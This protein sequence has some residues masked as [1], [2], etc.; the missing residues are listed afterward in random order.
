ME[1]LIGRKFNRLTVIEFDHK[2]KYYNSFWK[3]R[4]DC[5]NEVIVRA[6]GLRSGASKS[7]GCLMRERARE[8]CEL[9]NTTHGK[10]KTRLNNIWNN[11]KQRCFNPSNPDY[12]RWYGSRGIS[13]CD[14]WRNDFESFYLWSISHG[15]SD[16]LTIDRID[17]DGDYCP[18]NCQWVSMKEQA[19]N[20][21]EKK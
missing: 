19:K 14:E 20:R 4:C 1:N 6:G 11:M 16:N 17:N 5:G 2:D 3:C 18:E 12:I 13:M 10:S 7:C 21:R 15:Y 9:R 8:I